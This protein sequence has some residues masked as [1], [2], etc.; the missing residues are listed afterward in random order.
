MSESSLMEQ[1][2]IVV[3]DHEEEPGVETVST[4]MKISSECEWSVSAGD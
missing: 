2:D 4:M 1:V 3:E